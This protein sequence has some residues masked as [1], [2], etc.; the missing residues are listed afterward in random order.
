MSADNAMNLLSHQV[1]RNLK[2]VGEPCI[3]PDASK[4]AYTLSWI[5][6]EQLQT[7][8]QIIM[9]DLSDGTEHKFTRGPNDINAKFSPSGNYLAFLRPTQTSTINQNETGE[10]SDD[11]QNHR[12]LW[13][14]PTDGGEA[15]QLSHVEGD[16]FSYSWSN[17]SES[18]AFSARVNKSRIKLDSQPQ[19]IH[20]TELDY[21][22]DTLGWKGE[23]R[24]H[25]FSAN[26]ATMETQQLTDGDWDDTSPVWS[27]D[28][29]SIAFISSRLE[30]RR[31]RSGTEAYVISNQ[32]GEPQLWSG[33]LG[34]IGA[35]AWSPNGDRLLALASEYP[36]YMVIWQSWLYFLEPHSKPIRLSDDSFRPN[37]AFPSWAES[38]EIRWQESGDI[39]LLGDHRGES[40]LYQVSENTGTA[41]QLLG[42]G[43]QSNSLSIDSQSNIAVI[44]S[45]NP[46]LP[47][48]LDCYQLG[49]NPRL[50]TRIDQHNQKYLDKT[51][52]GS[53]HRST[54]RRSNVELDCRLFLPPDFDSSG[55]Y[56]LILDVH[57]GPN[58]AF[59][60]SFSA[61]QQLLS[62]NGFLVLAVNP[63]GSSTY[64]NDFMESVIGDWGGEDYL[65]LMATVDDFRQLTYV[66][67]NRLGIHGYSYGGYMTSWIIGQTN[68]FKSAVVGAPCTDL[69]G[70]YGTSDI[71][72]TFGEA[73]W[74]SNPEDESDAT[75]PAFAERLLS[76]SPI[77]YAPSVET[78]VLLL[79][80]ESDLR[81]PITQS[82]A[83]F[84]I[85][86]RLGKT[87]EF[88]RFPDCSHLFLR[89]GPT[90]L[91]EEYL[92]R[93]IEWFQR[94]L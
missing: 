60:D 18:I 41:H 76:R 65:D 44:G 11:P 50:L 51:A 39:L 46:N 45:S 35:L 23:W 37:V 63:R 52:L 92:K 40:Y 22:H 31:L 8:S 33:H 10:V 71:G 67:S 19:A 68:L 61:W 55:T 93:T 30:N 84:T 77:T 13:V 24:F 9:R 62:S 85:L 79:H 25:I 16:I 56:P 4:L 7:R 17:D 27:P 58:G 70:M 94:Y 38:A 32:G 36:G 81:C 28:G 86:K 54:V 87:V 78:P 2:S 57:G 3:S 69:F 15:S 1:V 91:K 29:S 47:S 49:P 75:Q 59:Y 5:D 43:C 83:Y 12:Q 74:N 48:Y 21:R 88:V 73:Q 53:M 14:I 89:Y 34:G 64:G 20:I 42:G 26:V 80:G 66:D 90:V 72:I 6:Q 82:E